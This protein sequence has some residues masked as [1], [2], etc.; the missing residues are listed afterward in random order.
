MRL[1]ARR[2]E[3]APAEAPPEPD[4]AAIAEAARIA[5][6]VDPLAARPEPVPCPVPGPVTGPL[7]ARLTSEDV[8]AVEAALEGSPKELWDATP[9]EHRPVLVLIFGAF[10]DIPSVMNKT[11]LTRAAPPEDIHA[12]ARG[13]LTYA[14]DPLLADMV[15]LAFEEAGVPLTSEGTVLDFGCSS[16]RI[17]RVLAA[18]YPNA[19][20]IGCDPNDAA[21]AWAVEHLPMARFFASTTSPP[22][23]LADGSVD[24]A[25]AI[26]IWSHFDSASALSWLSEM[27]RIIRPG[28]ALLVTTHGLDTLG[29]QLR[30]DVMTHDS[31]AEA[32]ETM[33]RDGHKYFDVF[34]ED[35][36]WGVK[37]PG[38]GNSYTGVDWLAA[39]V[40]PAWSIRL[41]RPAMLAQNQDVFVL[42]RRA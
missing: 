3:P 24:W 11:G 18:L 5:A 6:F 1:R 2:P 12:M 32:M 9:V 39:N 37:D 23:E 16:G 38:W 21:I 25:Y 15:A 34:G 40:T 17:L 13:V 41:F 42:E 35:G 7:Y 31:A 28:G 19:H 8:A 20:H 14:G 27:H 10:Y 33:L 36:D 29:Q 26:S 4:S 30:G 22:L